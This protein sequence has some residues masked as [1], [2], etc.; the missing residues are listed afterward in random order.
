[1]LGLAAAL[2]RRGHEVTL[3]VS[4]NFRALAEATGARYCEGGGDPQAMMRDEGAG[5]ANPVTFLKLARVE[6]RRQFAFLEEAC[7]GA[8]V[9]VGTALLAAGQTVAER[10]GLPYFGAAYFPQVLPSSEVWPPMF[11]HPR[12]PR[13]LWPLGWRVYVAAA[14]LALLRIVNEERARHGLD[15]VTSLVGESAL[16]KGTMLCAFDERVAPV[17]RDWSRY[18]V[19]ATGFWYFDDGPPL[20]DELEAFLDAGAPPVFISFGSMPARD[21]A[22][23]S[24]V[25]Q[26]ALARV[27]CRAVIGAGWGGIGAGVRSAATFVVEGALDHRRLFPRCAA[28]VHHG[29]A[30]TTAQ[31]ARAA[32]PQIVVPHMFDQ[33]HW[34]ARVHA[35]GVAPQPLRV[36]FSAAALAGALTRVFADDD[37]RARARE[38]GAALA[39]SQ[40]AERAAALIESGRGRQ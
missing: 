7:A 4:P 31:A 25:V 40:G 16:K 23:T 8:D 17:P 13:L 20:S 15:T 10:N 3:C 32:V 19:H 26:E 11:G 30:G 5:I 29:G 14:N 22:H 24:R 38:L 35:I 34:A 18:A 2:L 36:R 9:L 37:M 6:V 12:M 28:V 39:A 27:G 1:M 21:P 33:H